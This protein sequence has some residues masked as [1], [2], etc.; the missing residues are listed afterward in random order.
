M[1]KNALAQTSLV[2]T[3]FTCP[4]VDFSCQHFLV[5]IYFP[6]TLSI[7]VPVSSILIFKY[8]ILTPQRGSKLLYYYI[9]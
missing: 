8:L 2:L 3:S 1:S 4:S 7:E 9:Y 5:E 6:G